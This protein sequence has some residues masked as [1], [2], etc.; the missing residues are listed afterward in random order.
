MSDKLKTMSKIKLK[1]IPLFNG[2]RNSGWTEII[3]FNNN[4]ICLII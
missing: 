3:M 1:I 4:F 2:Y